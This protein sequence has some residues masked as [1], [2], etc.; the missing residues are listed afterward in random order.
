MLRSL[1]RLLLLLCI[2]TAVLVGQT[3]KATIRGTVTDSTGGMVP[4]TAITITEI[5][6]N[7]DRQ[8][9][10]DTNGNYE[11]PDLRPG[12][13]RVKADKT[14]FRSYIASEV[15]LDVGQVRRVD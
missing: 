13:Y 1:P 8:I 14:G 15:L 12:M 6:T 10:S 9:V 3:E 7:I 4:Q 5:S 2:F 11:V